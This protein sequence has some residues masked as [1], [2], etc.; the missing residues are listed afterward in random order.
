[1]VG[2]G[3]VETNPPGPVQRKVRFGVGEVHVKVT[4]VFA[5]VSTPETEANTTGLTTF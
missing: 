5:Q 4:D 2:V 3:A 1:M